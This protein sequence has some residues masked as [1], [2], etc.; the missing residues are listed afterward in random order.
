LHENAQGSVVTPMVDAQ[1]HAT[2]PNV[3]EVPKSK[4]L[5]IVSRAMA[6]KKVPKELATSSVAAV[7]DDLQS[8]GQNMSGQHSVKL[9]KIP[10]KRAPQ[11]VTPIR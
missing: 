1:P 8:S 9:Q 7:A 11:R 4:G 10:S 6:I 5:E 2:G 3:D